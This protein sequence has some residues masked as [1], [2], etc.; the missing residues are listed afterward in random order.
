MPRFLFSTWRHWIVVLTVLAGIVAVALHAPV[1]Q[2]P[3]FH[4]FAD[5]RPLWHLPNFWNVLSNLPFFAAMLAGLIALFGRESRGFLPELRL[6]Y[7]TFFLGAGLVAAGSAYYH[8]SPNSATLVWDRLPMTVSFMAFFA[9]I[10]GEN[11]SVRLGR[12][13]L[14]PLVSIGLFSVIVW[15]A[16]ESAGAGDL[17]LYILVQFL[18]MLLIPLIMVLFPS[19]LCSQGFIVGVLVLYTLAKGLEFFDAAIY[20]AIPLSG[21]TLKHLAAAAAVLCMAL[22][23]RYRKPQIIVSH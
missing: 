9:I 19:R 10:L 20:R 17:R 23:V 15:H 21:H 5:S 3:A 14:L 16:T 11:L 6:G 18:P 13:C 2:D 1:P 7:F 8:L 4:H 12:L 22:A